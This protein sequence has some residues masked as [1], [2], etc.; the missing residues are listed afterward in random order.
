MYETGTSVTVRALHVMPGMEGPEGELHDHDY[1]IEVVASR[2]E[3]DD[4][5]MV[6]DLDLLDGALAHVASIVRD[7]N[8]EKIRPAEADAVTVEVFARWVH[9]AISERLPAD[10]EELA[11]RVWESP[12]A[13][14]GYRASTS[15]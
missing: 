11:I 1:R 14:G 6:V 7:E 5:G 10:G 2:T 12:T 9:G 15:S 13:F 4:Q 3:L 8:L